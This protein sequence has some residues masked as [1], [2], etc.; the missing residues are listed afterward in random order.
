MR[1]TIPGLTSD[2][3]P[4]L[5]FS[6]EGASA[7]VLTLVSRSIASICTRDNPKVG[8]DLWDTNWRYE[9]IQLDASIDEVKAWFE[10]APRMSLTHDLDATGK[11][12][13]RL[14]ENKTPLP[15]NRPKFGYS[16][17]GFGARYLKTEYSGTTDD[18]E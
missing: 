2:S 9:K 15:L 18:G 8:Y 1:E 17:F 4:A 16:H 13:I 14:A 5:V 12:Q 11:S 10:L 7:T 6:T 3:N